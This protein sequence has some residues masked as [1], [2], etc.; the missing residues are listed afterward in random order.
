MECGERGTL[1]SRVNFSRHVRGSGEGWV[2]A[3]V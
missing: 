3:A 1:V 2:G